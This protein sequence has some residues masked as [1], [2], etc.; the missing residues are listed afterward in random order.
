MEFSQMSILVRYHR[1]DYKAAVIGLQIGD[2]IYD[3]SDSYSS[4]TSWLNDSIGHVKSAITDLE[5]LAAKAAVSFPV[6]SQKPSVDKDAPVNWLAPIE[7]NQE[8]WAAGVTYERSRAARQEEAIDGGDVYA[9]VYGAQRPELF[10]KGRGHHVVGHLGEVGIRSDATWSV[11]EPELAV[12]FNPALE[13]V[14]FTVGND[15]SSRDIEGENPLYLPQA[16]VYTAACALGPGIVLSAATEFPQTTIRMEIVRAGEA[17]FAG[18]VHTDRLRRT[19]RELAD[20]LGRCNTYPDGVILLTGTGIVPPSDFTLA[21][22]DEVTISI[23]G[24]GT[25][26]NTVKVV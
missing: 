7:L 11:P 8:V 12:V 21:P 15:M 18:E 25:L 2:T 26:K 23:D 3:L 14:G 5:A 24:I 19:I 4:L 10:F 22:G 17:M 20:Y 9:R 16:K 13:V 6:E 1:H